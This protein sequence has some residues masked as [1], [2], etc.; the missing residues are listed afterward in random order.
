MKKIIIVNTFNMA[1]IFLKKG[2]IKYMWFKIF[3]HS[4]KNVHSVV[5][6]LENF[7]K[8]KKHNAHI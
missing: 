3:V 7:T 4:L 2:C 1:N 8:I 6:K 5:K